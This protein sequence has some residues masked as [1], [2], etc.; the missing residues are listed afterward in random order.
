MRGNRAGQ[1]ASRRSGKVSD[2]A[3]MTA[4]VVNC[5]VKHRAI[6]LRVRVV[7]Q[8]RHV[9]A[10]DD[11]ACHSGD[12]LML[13]FFGSPHPIACRR[14]TP[15]GNVGGHLYPVRGAE[16]L[17]K[18]ALAA[19]NIDTRELSGRCAA[20]GGRVSV[21]GVA[22]LRVG[23]VRSGSVANGVTVESETNGGQSQSPKAGTQ[24]KRL[25]VNRRP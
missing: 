25:E 13:L 18:S 12:V 4:T 16:T 1:C 10:H 23:S 5:E 15:T 2:T 14:H 6:D 22:R 17:L 3:Q 24:R 11:C 20:V 21:F 7:C 8:V 9:P 19:E